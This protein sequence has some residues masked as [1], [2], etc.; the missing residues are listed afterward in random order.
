VITLSAYTE[1]QPALIPVVN[2]QPQVHESQAQ[3]EDQ[4]HGDFAEILAGLI[5]KAG[6][7]QISLENEDGVSLV[8]FSGLEIDALPLSLEIPE[9]VNLELGEEIAVLD[10]P[11]ENPEVLLSAQHL[12]GRIGED[13]GETE[14]DLPQELSAADRANMRHVE[15]AEKTD[16][17]GV[18]AEAIVEDE[19][20]TLAQQPQAQSKEALAGT[21]PTKKESVKNREDVKI[22]NAQASA[23]NSRK[24]EES[25]SLKNKESSRFDDL[26]GRSKSRDKFYIDVRDM[27]TQTGTHAANAAGG[28]SGAEMKFNAGLDTSSTR[29]QAP[30][31]EITLELRL[32]DNNSASLGQ[33]MAQTAWEAKANAPNASSALENMLAR[34]L[35]QSFNGDIVRHASMALR[36]GGEGTIR[37]ALKPEHLGNVKIHL[38]MSENK[39]TGQIIVESEEALN[40]FKKE[41]ASLEQAFKEAGFNSANLNLSLTADGRE[42]QQQE[43]SSFMPRT[44]ASRYD[45]ASLFEG[46]NIATV[47]VYIGQRPNAI[48]MLA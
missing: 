20:V 1:P 33:S 45:D 12:L 8:D 48:N 5:N 44:I 15:S 26:R 41:I 17:A 9:E 31:N 16:A 29:V 2:E 19:A 43:A 34:E 35:H 10:L 47:D 13:S 23:I 22:D 25:S 38:E 21:E 4:E 6:N 46:G 32:P 39:I 42:A 40:A 27:R 36:D 30:V 11:E 14:R 24:T 7:E 37:I 3:E 18:T 28:A